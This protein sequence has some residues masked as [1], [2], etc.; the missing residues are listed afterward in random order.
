MLGKSMVE[1]LSG[2][3]QTPDPDKAGLLYRLIKVCEALGIKSEVWTLQTLLFDLVTRTAINPGKY[4]IE[5]FPKLL[6]EMDEF[7]HCR[8]LK[9]LDPSIKALSTT[10]VPRHVLKT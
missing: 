4:T 8:F 10:V 7:L 3:L 9:L 5:E 6:K 2:L 1:A